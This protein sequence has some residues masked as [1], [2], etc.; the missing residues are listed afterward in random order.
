MIDLSKITGFD[1]DKGNK[2]KSYTKHD[3]TPKEAEEIFL[4]DN[5]LLIEDI[6]HSQKEE[7]FIAIGKNTQNTILFAAFTLRDR[8]IRII[9]VRP[10]NIK[11]RRHYEKP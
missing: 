7:R 6:K 8:T 10:A 11:E 1:W 9:S 5:V 2:D 3:I 4:D